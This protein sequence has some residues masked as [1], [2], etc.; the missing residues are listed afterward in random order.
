MSTIYRNNLIL[1]KN[2]LKLFIDM[3]TEKAYK[4]TLMYGCIMYTS[5]C[6]GVFVGISFPAFALESST[7]FHIISGFASL[8]NSILI[9]II[10]FKNFEE[11]SLTH[12]R[13]A[14]DYLILY[15]AIVNQLVVQG[16][17]YAAFTA[18]AFH[19]YDSIYQSSPFVITKQLYDDQKISYEENI[20]NR[21]LGSEQETDRSLN[22]PKD[23]EDPIASSITQDI[24]INHMIQFELNRLN[25]HM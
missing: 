15:K 10:K 16:E 5:I 6:L 11:I 12:T 14:K 22:E 4:Y 9:S 7:L 19:K 18:W 13:A 21:A 17:D 3:H 24:P 2:D 25:I 23:D 8:I 1:L 20:I